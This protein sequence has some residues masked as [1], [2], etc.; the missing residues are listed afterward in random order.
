MSPVSTEPLTEINIT[1]VPEGKGRSEREDEYITAI[2]ERIV[3]TLWEPRHLTTLWV[4][5]VCYGDSF[6]LW[7]RSV[8][9]VRYELDCKYCYK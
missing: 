5:T 4:S 2:C 8:L 1:N 3:R 6:T 9:P 7:R